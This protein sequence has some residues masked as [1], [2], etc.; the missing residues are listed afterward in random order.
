M[1]TPPLA[2]PRFI[3][4]CVVK[5]RIMIARDCDGV[6]VGVPRDSCEDVRM[7]SMGREWS[8]PRFAART[9]R[10]LLV[11][12]QHAIGLLFASVLA[13]IVFDVRIQQ[14]NLEGDEFVHVVLVEQLARG[15]YTLRGTPVLRL[16]GFSAYLYGRAVHYNPPLYDLVLLSLKGFW[17]PAGYVRL[18]WL[19]SAGCAYLVY[20]ITRRR[21]SPPSA[22][23]AALVFLGCPIVYLVSCR[24]WAEAFLMLLICLAADGCDRVAAQPDRR[25]STSTIL[26]LGVLLAAVALTKAS[27]LFVLPGLLWLTMADGRLNRKLACTLLGVPMAVTLLWLG[28][29]SYADHA[30]PPLLP[31]TDDRFDNAFVLEMAHKPALSLFYLPL[32]LNPGYVVALAALTRA[33]RRKSAPFLLCVLGGIVA[34]SVIAWSGLGTFH[35]KYISC[36][37]PMLAVLAGIGFEAL[38]ASR[39][40]GLRLCIAAVI[41]ALLIY[42]N[43]VNRRTW[44]AEVSP[45]LYFGAADPSL[46]P[47]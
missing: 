37:L 17:S 35:T 7:R 44:V 4:A 40:S 29:V 15:L 20:R 8:I 18:S 45:A 46:S 36:V 19:S 1:L 47:P 27:V 2:A 14:T 31:L 28:Y 22:A 23:F 12:A 32:L 25:V 21:T 11:V 10:T 38:G 34:F 43:T 42:E 5:T 13:W 3:S 33:D 39:R 24:V 30:A 26:G 9:P 16:P 6:L 41:A